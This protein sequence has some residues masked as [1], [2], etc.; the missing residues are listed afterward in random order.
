VVVG[1]VLAGVV[2]TGRETPSRAA[3]STSLAGG[4][5]A[6]R[7]KAPGDGD[8]PKPPAVTRAAAAAAVQR[9]TDIGEPL[10]CGGGRK[11]VVALTFDD[12]P[13]PYTARTLRILRRH[14]ARATFF[15]VARQIEDWPG[16]RDIPA[17]EHRR[18][19][20]GNHSFD[21]VSL[22]GATQET[23]EHQVGDARD[24]IAEAAGGPVTLFRPPLGAR[25]ASVDA[26]V[27][28]HGMLQVL[29]SVDSLDSRG[30]TT[31]EVLA[32]VTESIRPGSI[33]LLHENRGTTLHALPDLLDLIALRGYRTVT[34]PEL[35]AIDPPTR[36]QLRSGT[37]P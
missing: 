37:C 8:G 23:L 29:W 35:L 21:H 20:V 24:A 9:F 25:D 7:E 4:D 34:I 14:D 26:S 31:V 16:L 5:V 6:E 17:R 19:A 32:N 13:G 22:T 10:R 36:G 3:S 33:V 28:A 11:P 15:L 18:H 30:A 2:L 12:G 1:A 27:E